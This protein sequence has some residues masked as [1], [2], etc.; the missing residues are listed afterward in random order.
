MSKNTFNKLVDL[1]QCGI[2]VDEPQ[3]RRSTSGNV[4]VYP[5][6]TVAVGLRY[7]GGT[8]VKDLDNIF[9]ISSSYIKVLVTRF[10]NIVNNCEELQIRVPT[11]TEELKKVANEWDVVSTAN[12]L[13]YGVVGAIDGWLACTRQP[14]TSKE[15]EAGN[16]ITNTTNYYSAD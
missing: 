10:L 14:S 9:G 5:H 2:M 13:Y 1:L 8:A 16:K 12:R 15:D 4:P 3:S 6:I 11:S 7:L